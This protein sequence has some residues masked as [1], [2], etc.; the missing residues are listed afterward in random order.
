MIKK[1][2]FIRQRVAEQMIPTENMVLISITQPGDKEVGLHPEW[3]AILR[4]EFDD[5]D[6]SM[7]PSSN[8]RSFTAWHA[9]EVLDFLEIY[10]DIDELIVHCMAGISRSAAVAKFAA[11]KYNC[12]EFL[13]MF[14]KYE[15]YNKWVYSSL[16]RAD[17]PDYDPYA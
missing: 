8:S 10:K 7:L 9:K 15:L 2:S 5:I 14:E 11:E 1:I 16:K 13:R 6:G 4:L 12:N 17:N 3:K